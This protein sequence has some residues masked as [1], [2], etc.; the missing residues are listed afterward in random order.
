MKNLSLPIKEKGGYLSASHML[1]CA[2]RLVEIPSE[3]LSQTPL[4]QKVISLDKPTQDLLM[5][6]TLAGAGAA[7]VL[8]SMFSVASSGGSINETI[9]YIGHI[10]QSFNDASSLMDISDALNLAIDDA[11]SRAPESFVRVWGTMSTG[12][13][14]CVRNLGQIWFLR[15]G[16]N[17]NL[18]LSMPERR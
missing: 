2:N 6:S 13:L 8:A 18:D 7:M 11:R 17:D 12:A 10:S 1:L 9:E 15:S 3:Y 4:F 5:H 14:N 16:D